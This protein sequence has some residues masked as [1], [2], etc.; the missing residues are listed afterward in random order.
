MKYFTIFL[1]LL[2]AACGRDT[3]DAGPRAAAAVAAIALHGEAPN[4]QRAASPAPS[5]PIELD[6]QMPVNAPPDQ[7]L[8]IDLV[9]STSLDSGDMVVSVTKQVGIT[10]LSDAVRHIDLA[11]A[12]RPLRLPLEI[13]PSAAAQRSL[14]MLVSVGVG[15]EQQ[16][17]SFLIS[18]PS[19]N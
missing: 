1:S 2:I 6:Y 17:R 13:L 12:T 9:L 8:T 18:L 16:A 5:A 3:S 19:T 11:Q 4:T 10:L 7:T 15:G 14:V